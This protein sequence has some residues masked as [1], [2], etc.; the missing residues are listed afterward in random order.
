[1][2][3]YRV[4]HQGFANGRLI[5]LNECSIQPPARNGRARITGLI[6]KQR[7]IAYRSLQNATCAALL[8][9]FFL[10][11]CSALSLPTEEAPAAGPD[12]AFNT[13]I[14]EHIKGSF[15]DYASYD[16]FEISEYRWVHSAKGW[17]WVTCVHFQ[18][19]GRR[20]T[21]ALFIK[22]KEIVENRY[23]VATDGCGAQTYSQFDLM[24]GTKSSGNS[25]LLEPLY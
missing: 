22:Q 1:M 24:G 4:R 7:H 9:P 18:D 3:F 17:S 20:L 8:L 12:P 25:G 13:L 16:A 19:K 2:S 23:A 10:L 11:G 14:A 15:K 5:A 6:A 21:Y